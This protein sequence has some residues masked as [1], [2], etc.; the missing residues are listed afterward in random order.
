MV[1][2][3][4]NAAPFDPGEGRGDEERLRQETLQPARAPDQQL[5]LASQFL[6]AEQRD[7]VAQ[8]TRNVPSVGA[9]PPPSSDMFL[10]NDQ[11][12]EQDGGRAQRVDRR[13]DPLRGKIARQHDHAVHMGAD[14]GNRRIGEIVRRDID[15]LDRRDGACGWRRRY[16]PAG[17][18]PRFPASAGSPPGTACAPAGQRPRRPPERSGRRCPSAAARCAGPG[19]GCVRQ[20]SW[21]SAAPASARPAARSSGRRRAPSGRA[22]RSF[23]CR[24]ASRGPRGSARRRPRRPTRRHNPVTMAWISSVTSTVLPTPA[25]PNSAALP[26]CAS[27]ASRS[28]TLMPVEKT[29]IPARLC[30]RSGTGWWIARRAV[31]GGSAGRCRRC[32]RAHPADA[33]TARPCPPAPRSARPSPA[34]S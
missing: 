13:I 32:G 30:V 24:A 10:A 29:S 4:G 7:H 26:P 20:S 34:P 16:A 5:L 8:F 33:L 23:S 6:D 31:S 12:V 27:G 2:G 18:Q 25:P 17:R 21:R 3:H 22:R 15:G 14:R 9:R 11:R 1:F 19:R 28:R